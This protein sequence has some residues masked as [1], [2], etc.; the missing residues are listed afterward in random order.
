MPFCE[1][2]ARHWT[3]PSLGPEG[4]CPTC[5]ARLRDPAT[6]P[7]ADAAGPTGVEPSTGP[8]AAP[9]GEGEAQPN[10]PWHFTLL[11]IALVLYLGFRAYQ[12]IAWLIVHVF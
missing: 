1:A 5:G 10:V 4:N 11:L 6:V 9:P 3:P 2:C 8:A 7:D 12:G